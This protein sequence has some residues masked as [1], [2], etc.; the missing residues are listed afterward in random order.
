MFSERWIMP[1]TRG[2]KKGF[3]SSTLSHPM[4]EGRGEGEDKRKLK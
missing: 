2:D 1:P 4:G 3:Q